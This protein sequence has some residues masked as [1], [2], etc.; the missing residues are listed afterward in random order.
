MHPVVKGKPH[1]RR[2]DRLASVSAQ[3]NRISFGCINV[4]VPFYNAVISPAFTGTTASST[5]CRKRARLA[6]CSVLPL[7]WGAGIR[8][9]QVTPAGPHRYSR[10]GRYGHPDGSERIAK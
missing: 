7:S 8:P 3:D 2:A 9:Q 6:R 4:P 5:S 10:V 1:E